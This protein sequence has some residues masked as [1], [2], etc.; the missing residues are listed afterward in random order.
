MTTPITPE[1]IAR[2]RFYANNGMTKAQAN[3]IYGIPRHA[4]RVA[5]EKYDVRFTTGY[6][7]GVE[8]AFKNL[9]DKEYEEKDLIYKSTVQRNRYDQYKEILKTAKTAAERKEITYGF[10]LHEF[11][12]TQAAKNNRP[13]LPGF[14]SKFSTLNSSLLSTGF[15]LLV[16]IRLSFK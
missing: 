13:P 12:L 7:T 15:P 1:L 10:V 9:T 14:T 8:R 3:R 2:I 11:E 16:A 6:T 4:I 5:I